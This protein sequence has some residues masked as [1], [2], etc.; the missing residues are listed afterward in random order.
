MSI[1]VHVHIIVVLP[2]ITALSTEIYTH[3]HYLTMMCHVRYTV[4][5]QS[6]PA[7]G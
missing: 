7:I 3:S 4:L 1:A 2:G 6:Y 5:V